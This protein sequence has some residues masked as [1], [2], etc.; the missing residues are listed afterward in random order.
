MEA[1]VERVI[2]ELGI[3]KRLKRA[4]TLLE[5]LRTK[6]TH[7]ESLRKCID[8]KCW[9]DTSMVHEYWICSCD[10]D[11]NYHCGCDKFTGRTLDC[12]SCIEPTCEKCITKSGVCVICVS[13]LR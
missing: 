3:L 4:E 5:R 12:T 2:Q 7:V 8:C 10:I 1:F 11:E 9:I 6:S 13:W